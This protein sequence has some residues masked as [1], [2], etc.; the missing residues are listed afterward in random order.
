M[1][2]TGAAV[3]DL[4]TLAIWRGEPADRWPAEVDAIRA[5]GEPT[6]RGDLA[7]TGDDLA[8]AGIP[9][10][11]AI[12]NALSALLDAVLDDPARNTRE[13]LIALARESR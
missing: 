8:A 3:D 9:V 6:A 1:A 5:R 13:R 10:G 2:Q 4:R 12:G 7:V 11:P